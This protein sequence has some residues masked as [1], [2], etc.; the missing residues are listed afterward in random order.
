MLHLQ[1][2]LVW[3]ELLRPWD[4]REGGSAPPPQQQQ[5]RHKGLMHIT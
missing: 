1:S 4:G 3:L 5:A 2:W